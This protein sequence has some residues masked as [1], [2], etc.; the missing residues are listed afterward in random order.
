[1]YGDMK[2]RPGSGQII[3]AAS[4]NHTRSDVQHST[5]GKIDCT[6]LSDFHHLL[7]HTKFV[8]VVLPF[9]SFPEI[10]VNMF[11]LGECVGGRESKKV[12]KTV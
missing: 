8:L 4:H 7:P 12:R 11:V 5:H 3:N 2:C 10:P 1:M 6:C 9:L